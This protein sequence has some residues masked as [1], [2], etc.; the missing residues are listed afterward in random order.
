MTFSQSVT[1]KVIPT[2]NLSNVSF[3]TAVRAAVD[4]ISTN[5]ARRAFP[6]R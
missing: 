2:A 6:L 3:R 4:K 1:L 5:I